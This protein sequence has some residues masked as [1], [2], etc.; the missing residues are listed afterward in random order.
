MM[1]ELFRDILKNPLGY[2]LLHLLIVLHYVGV[3]VMKEVVGRCR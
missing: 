1:C 2:N 3:K